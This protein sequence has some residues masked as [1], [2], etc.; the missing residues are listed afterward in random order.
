M[1][2]TAATPALVSAT[3][4]HAT[5]MRHIITPLLLEVME[6]MWNSEERSPS[7]IP[8][9]T[10]AHKSR[11]GPTCS[12]PRPAYERESLRYPKYYVMEQKKVVV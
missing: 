11:V 6:T 4:R 5:K 8:V 1:T 12:W 10:K 3:L 2:H 9:D 7:P